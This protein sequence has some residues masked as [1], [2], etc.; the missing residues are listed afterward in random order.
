MLHHAISKDTQLV[1]PASPVAV[2][3]PQALSSDQA[4]PGGWKALVQTGWDQGTPVPA[5]TSSP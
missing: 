5:D 1:P 4:H 3:A 2:P